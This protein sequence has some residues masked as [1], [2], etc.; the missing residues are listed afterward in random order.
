[1]FVWKYY[2]MHLLIFFSVLSKVFLKSSRRLKMLLFT[3]MVERFV[4]HNLLFGC[5]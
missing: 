4:R 3:G 2:M 1:M 5:L